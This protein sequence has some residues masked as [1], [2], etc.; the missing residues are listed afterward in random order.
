MASVHSHLPLSF[1]YFLGGFAMR[2]GNMSPVC[3]PRSPFLVAWRKKG[4]KRGDLRT[5]NGTPTSYQLPP[6]SATTQSFTSGKPNSFLPLSH[7]AHQWSNECSIIREWRGRI[8]LGHSLIRPLQRHKTQHPF[9]AAVRP[10]QPSF[11]WARL[12]QLQRSWCEGRELGAQ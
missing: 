12:E 11:P 4:A 2:L 1:S 3:K 10:I 6:V 9:R 7:W 8:V 5:V